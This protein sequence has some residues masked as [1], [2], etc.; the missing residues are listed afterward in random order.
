MELFFQLA[1][2]AFH[3]DQDPEWSATRWHSST[4]S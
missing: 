3:R 2:D 4:P 1:A